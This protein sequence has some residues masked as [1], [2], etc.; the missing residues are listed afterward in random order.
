MAVVVWYSV[1]RNVFDRCYRCE[2]SCLCGMQPAMCWIGVTG[3]NS[4]L[5]GVQPAMCWIGVTG[6]NC[7]VSVVYSQ[8]CVG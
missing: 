3:V 4:C 5:C 1:A 8:R 7:R 2:L 6:V